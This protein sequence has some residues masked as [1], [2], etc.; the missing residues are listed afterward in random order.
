MKIDTQKPVEI[1]IESIAF[2]GAGVG[3]IDLSEIRPQ[4]LIQPGSSNPAPSRKMAVFVEGA[5]PGDRILARIGSDKRNYLI[6][7]I[8]EFIEKSPLRITPHCPHFCSAAPL[9]KAS[10]AGENATPRKSSPCNLL[11]GGCSLQSLSYEDQLSIKEQHV[12]DAVSR[13][14]G[15][16]AGIVKPIIGCAEPWYYRNKMDFSFT[17]MLPPKTPANTGAASTSEKSSFISLGLHMRRRHHDVVEVTECYLME[18]YVGELVAKVRAHFKQAELP[19]EME[20]KSLIIRESK[21]TGETM[22]NLLADNAGLIQQ[23]KQV[24]PTELPS[25]LQDFKQLIL[26]F[27]AQNKK[28]LTSLYF[29]DTLNKKGQSNHSTEYLLHGKPSIKEIMHRPDNTELVF[30]ISPQSFFQPNTRQAEI[31]YTQA[32]NAAALTGSET[33]FDLYC[34]AGTIGIFCANKAKKIYGI[35]ISKAAVQNAIQNAKDNRIENIEFY[36]GDT[37]KELEADLL[38]I[39]DNPDLIILDPPRNGLEPGALENIVR[40]KAPRLVYISCNPTTQARDLRLFATH[41]YKLLSIQPVD[42]FPQTY[43]IESVAALA[44]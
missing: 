40:F 36:C 8:I 6:G 11:C 25:F 12:R 16:D 18:P 32:L 21:N 41:G 19:P 5:V 1:L 13:I 24:H 17:K 2:G 33:V 7:Y 14:G 30:H 4:H 39:K 43:H 38:K 34:G 37:Q 10:A 29:T 22:V 31:L 44:L 20:L 26:D 28:D 27:F 3:R 35:E 42:M 23:I 15:F 9:N